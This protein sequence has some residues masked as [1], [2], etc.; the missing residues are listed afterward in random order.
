MAGT[1]SDSG[2]DTPESL[3]AEKNRQ[4]EIFKSLIAQ[5]SGSRAEQSRKGK[6]EIMKEDSMGKQ[7]ELH[8]AASSGLASK[9]GKYVALD[10]EMV[11]VGPQGEQSVLAR[12]SLVNF[13]GQVVMD[14]LVKPQEK[15]TDYRTHITGITHGDLED[16]TPFSVVQ[17]RVADILKDRIV[18]GHALKND[19][20]CLYLSHPVAR[21]RDTSGYKPF[22]KLL[23]TKKP[24]LKRL[25]KEVLGVE[26]QTGVHSSVEDARI[27]MSL[28]RKHKREFE[29]VLSSRK[30]VQEDLAIRQF[31]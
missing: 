22:K 14:E 3:L 24:S 27:A 5:K 13:Y 7:F 1:Q 9:I 28:F 17:R 29:S 20:T 2:V 30:K 4:I 12:V 10:C 15:V 31:F 8:D 19:F 21:T 6:R 25:A 16:A 18:V 26:I 11:G 23:K